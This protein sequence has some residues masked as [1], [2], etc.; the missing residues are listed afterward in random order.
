MKTFELLV[1]FLSMS[2]SL[3]AQGK[4][5]PKSAPGTYHRDVEE[6]IL[7]LA[8]TA[9]D[10]V[11]PIVYWTDHAFPGQELFP[12]DAGIAG[13]GFLVDSRGDFE[14]AAHVLGLKQ[15]GPQERPIKVYLPAMIRQGNGS[16]ISLRF[17]VIE[18]D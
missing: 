16:G 5:L 13:T 2:A 1:L 6:L 7:D 12:V 10:A 15:I 9:S 14:T 18:V 8:P 17:N 11:I 3:A 4:T